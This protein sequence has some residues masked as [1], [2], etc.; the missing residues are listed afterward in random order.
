MLSDGTGG[1]GGGGGAMHNHQRHQHQHHHQHHHRAASDDFGTVGSNWSDP[2]QLRRVMQPPQP[3]SSNSSSGKGGAIGVLGN[4]PLIADDEDLAQWQPDLVLSDASIDGVGGDSIASAN[5]SV[6]QQQQQQQQPHQHQQTTGAI[7]L[8][9]NT[10]SDI[11]LRLSALDPLH[12]ANSH[13]LELMDLSGD[14]GQHSD[15]DGGDDMHDFES[16]ADSIEFDS[17]Q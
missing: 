14:E 9:L 7:N 11:S 6:H 12:P 3:S 1:G 17:L 16:V 5:S 2:M 4:L 10:S 15:A 8:S 13:R